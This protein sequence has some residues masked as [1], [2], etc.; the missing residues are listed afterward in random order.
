MRE[1]NPETILLVAT[2][3]TIRT[4]LDRFAMPE[5]RSV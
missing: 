4:L 3:L 5:I 1:I 2:L